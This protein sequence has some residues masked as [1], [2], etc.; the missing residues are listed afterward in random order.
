M[1]EEN[2]SSENDQSGNVVLEGKE[3]TIEELKAYLEMKANA[4]NR[5]N[6]SIFKNSTFLGRCKKGEF[7][8]P[9]Q[10]VDGN[11]N[12]QGNAQKQIRR[13]NCP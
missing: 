3:I 7:N 4:Q 13:W 11:Y 6:L 10:I 1:V 8:A 9:K 2:K 5:D 12:V